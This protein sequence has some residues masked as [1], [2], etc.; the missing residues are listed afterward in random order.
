M[1]HCDWE[2]ELRWIEEA[3]VSLSPGLSDAE[4][5]TAERIHGF[6]F[7]PDLRSLLSTALPVGKG[8]PNWRYPDSKDIIDQ[9]DWPA[10]G[11]AF[12]VEHNSIWFDEW[13]S[14]PNDLEAAVERA[15][16]VIKDA[17]VLI[18]I[19][20]HRYMP[21]EPCESGNPVF[22]VYQMDIIYYGLDL[23]SF[24]ANEFH[25]VSHAQAISG[26][27]KQVTFWNNLVG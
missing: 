25:K 4:L 14:K 2:R 15:R 5:S 8:F 12:D 10:D 19:V 3:G 23:H 7:P 26:V 9:L 20:G 16:R 18:P 1:S 11:I 22:S 17:P 13:G 27:P 21:S 24:F 6:A